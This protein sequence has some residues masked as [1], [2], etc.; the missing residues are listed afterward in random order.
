[1]K[2]KMNAKATADVSP[3]E[4]MFLFVEGDD[5]S[6]RKAVVVSKVGEWWTMGALI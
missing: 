6:Q 3:E 1:M 4:R 2:L 5:L